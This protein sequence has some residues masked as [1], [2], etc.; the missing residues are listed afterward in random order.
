[1]S[2]QLA[3]LIERAIVGAAPVDGDKLAGVVAQLM[4]SGVNN[5]GPAQIASSILDGIRTAS[6]RLNRVRVVVTG[7]GWVG[8]GVGSVEETLLGVV[9]QAQHEILAT[10]YTITAGSSRILEQFEHA[11]ATGVRVRL[12]VDHFDH[13]DTKVREGLRSL[14]QRFPTTFGVYDFTGV[15]GSGQLHAKSLVV[16][17]RRAVVG[18]ANLTFHGMIS[19]HEMAVV[20]DGPAAEQIAG[21]ID[22]LMHF[23][24]VRSLAQ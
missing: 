15:S 17:R 6:H 8:G 20:V 4:D 14:A 22:L 5:N 7:I 2:A 10:A 21:R 19:A 18:S 16:D 3:A 11:A 23:A 13:Q 1:M 9:R 24:G 12:I